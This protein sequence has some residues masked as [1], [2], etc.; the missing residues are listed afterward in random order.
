MRL[1]LTMTQMLLTDFAYLRKAAH[2]CGDTL[3]GVY[4][5]KVKKPNSKF[6]VSYKI[7]CIF[8]FIY[9]E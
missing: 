8:P 3:L 1:K 9:F 6:T 7:I 4:G 2:A 5:A